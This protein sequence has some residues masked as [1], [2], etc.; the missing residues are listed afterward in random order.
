MF[1]TQDITSPGEARIDTNFMKAEALNQKTMEAERRAY[2]TFFDV[3]VIETQ[4]GYILLEEGDYGELPTHLI[5][6]VVYTAQ[7]KM[8]DE[9]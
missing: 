1:I 5:D 8:D 2:H 9:F 6:D 4:D 7:G 3:H